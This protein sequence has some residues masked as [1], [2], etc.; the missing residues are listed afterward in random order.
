MQPIANICVRLIERQKFRRSAQLGDSPN[1][2][3]VTG[4]SGSFIG[5]KFSDASLG[6]SKPVSSHNCPVSPHP[7]YKSAQFLLL[8]LRLFKQCTTL[9]MPGEIARAL[10]CRMQ[11]SHRASGDIFVTVNHVGQ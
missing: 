5:F 11:S 8:G 6:R 10:D 1:H 3:Q 2:G 4:D 9:G 7:T